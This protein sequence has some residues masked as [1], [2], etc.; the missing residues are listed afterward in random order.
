LLVAAGRGPNVQGLNL[1]N[2]GVEYDNHGVKTD[3]RLRTNQKH[4]FAAGDVLGKYKFT[5]A[6][7]YEGGIVI[8]NVVFRLPR[9]VDYTWL[10]WCTYTQP[11]LAHIGMNEK[12]AQKAEIEYTTWEEDFSDNDRVQAEGET[13]GKIKLVLD[14]REKPLGVQIVG[15]HAGEL[16]AEWVAILNSRTGLSTLASAVHPYPTVSEVNKKVAGRFL[17]SKIFSEKVRKTLGFVF[18]YKGRACSLD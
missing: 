12:A 7:G 17:S 3:L 18:D 15:I 8:S 5:H 1:E 14:K 10:P 9:K 13:C 2:A 16:V 6:A 4:I 11:E